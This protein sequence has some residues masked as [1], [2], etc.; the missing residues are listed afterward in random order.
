MVFSNSARSFAQTVAASTGTD[1]NPP[2]GTEGAKGA[3]DEH[4]DGRVLRLV[5]VSLV[6]IRKPPWLSYGVKC[7]CSHPVTM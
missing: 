1:V 4:E 3:E 6:T 7:L 2:T 5:V